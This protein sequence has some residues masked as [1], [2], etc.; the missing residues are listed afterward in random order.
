MVVSNVTT[1]RFFTCTEVSPQCPVQATTLGYYPIKGV[2][3]FFA[4]GFGLAGLAT[5]VCGTWKKTWTY[6]AFIAIGCI[7]ELAGAFMSSL[8]SRATGTKCTRAPTRRYRGLTD[9]LS[10]VRITSA[11]TRKPMEPRRL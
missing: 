1:P 7:L 6:M 3:I 5:I 11:P 8:L 10:R 4:A 9:S 2:N